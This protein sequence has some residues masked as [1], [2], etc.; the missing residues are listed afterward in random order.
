M[1]ATLTWRSKANFA[2][3][4]ELVFD[5]VTDEDAAGS[6]DV[7][8][9]N[10][11]RTSDVDM[12]TAS[13]EGADFPP[14]AAVE[15]EHD[16]DAAGDLGG[17][18][19]GAEEGRNGDVVAVDEG[20]PEIVVLVAL[21]HR[22]DSGGEGDLLVA[23]DGEDGE[24]VVVNPDVVVRVAGFD[25]DLDGGGEDVGGGDVE[26]EDGGVPEIKPGLLRLENR[27][28][29]DTGILKLGFQPITNNGKRHS[30]AQI[31]PGL[32]RRQNPHRQPEL[33]APGAV[34]LTFHLLQRRLSRAAFFTRRARKPGR[35]DRLAVPLQL[36]GL[37]HVVGQQELVVINHRLDPLEHHVE[38]MVRIL[39]REIR[40]PQI[41]ARSWQPSR[42]SRKPRDTKSH[43][44]EVTSGGARIPRA[45][46]PRRRCNTRGAAA[47]GSRSAWADI[48]GG[49]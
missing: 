49:G 40:L 13:Y 27:P 24:A 19:H 14:N 7:S 48:G 18:E 39:H 9:R 15:A 47:A 5:G 21:V 1:T 36:H 3:L 25:G 10:I 42:G 45:P 43:A 38:P 23:V 17:G 11:R 44:P 16:L 34:Q 2:P 26:V 28:D 12:V 46:A 31:R 20:G 41:T 4:D 8:E 30:P 29:S 33:Q 32:E 35:Q 37:L 22:R 6:G